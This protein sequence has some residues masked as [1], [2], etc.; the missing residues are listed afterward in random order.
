[1]N[2]VSFKHLSE[3]FMVQ[4]AQIIICLFAFRLLLKWNSRLIWSNNNQFALL[5]MMK[6]LSA[7]SRV[8]DG[9]SESGFKLDK[10]VNSFYVNHHSSDLFLPVST[11]AT[12]KRNKLGHIPQSGLIST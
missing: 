8:T 5:M 9:V 12:Q 1:M 6:K 11:A 4:Q 2:R 10:G 3:N 7:K